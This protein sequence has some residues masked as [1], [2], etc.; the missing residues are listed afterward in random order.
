MSKWRAPWFYHPWNGP[1]FIP[2]AYNLQTW[3]VESKLLA[4]EVVILALLTCYTQGEKLILYSLRHPCSLA[5]LKL[6]SQLFWCFFL[7]YSYMLNLLIS[8]YPLRLMVPQ[9][10]VCSHTLLSAGIALPILY[11]RD[12]F[13]GLLFLSCL[14]PKYLPSRENSFSNSD[15][16]YKPGSRCDYGAR[17]QAT[18]RQ[19]WFFLIFFLVGLELLPS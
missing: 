11:P 2:V 5:K 1:Q 10:R 6:W 17:G 4:L 3:S 15:P 18:G 12:S 8:I 13:H 14:A 16:A 9:L 7:L 19:G